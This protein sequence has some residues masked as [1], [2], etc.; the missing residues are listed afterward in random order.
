MDVDDNVDINVGDGLKDYYVAKIEQLQVCVLIMLWAMSFVSKCVV[1]SSRSRTKP[2]I[3]DDCKP[4]E[5]SWTRKVSRRLIDWLIDSWAFD[6]EANKVLKPVFF[7]LVWSFQFPAVHWRK[8]HSNYCFSHAKRI[9]SFLRGNCCEFHFILSSD[10]LI[11]WLIDQTSI[12]C[13]KCSTENS[14]ITLL[15]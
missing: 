6:L 11:D 9:C 4:S 1:F 3:S 5:M 7:R 12:P 2:R 14:R 10:Q 8:H 15:L 13:D